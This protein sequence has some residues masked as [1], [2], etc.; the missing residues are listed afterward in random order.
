MTIKSQTKASLGDPFTPAQIHLNDVLVALESHKGLS[1]TRRRDLRSSIK[2]VASLVGDDPARIAL[3]LPAISA[4]LATISPAAAG[5]TNKSFS[6]IRSD[7]MAAVMASKLKSVQRSAKAPLSA[8]WNKLIA[9][10]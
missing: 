8:A 3:D 5:L 1:E 10:L 4:K 9:D 2:R 6:N 7:F